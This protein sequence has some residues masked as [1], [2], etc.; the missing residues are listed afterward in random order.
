MLPTIIIIMSKTL[1]N[2]FGLLLN[3]K[4][5]KK[6]NVCYIYLLMLTLLTPYALHAQELVNLNNSDYLQ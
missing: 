3:K 2:S 6:H 1:Y 4:I 5:N